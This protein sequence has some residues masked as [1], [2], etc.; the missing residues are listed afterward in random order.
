MQQ[1]LAAVQLCEYPSISPMAGLHNDIFL[2]MLY[3]PVRVLLVFAIRHP[4]EIV[5]AV[6]NYVQIVTKDNYYGHAPREVSE[7]LMK[8][9]DDL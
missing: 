4:Q 5:G 6:R 8:Y 1:Y 7:D 3:H 2:K 9:Y